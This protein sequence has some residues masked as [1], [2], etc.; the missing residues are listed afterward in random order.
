MSTLKWCTDSVF[1]EE[2]ICLMLTQTSVLLNRLTYTVV[3][4]I[5]ISMFWARSSLS[6]DSLLLKFMLLDHVD[7]ASTWFS[8]ITK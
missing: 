8:A 2:H 6:N 4:Y 5:T 1:I 3:S 7:S